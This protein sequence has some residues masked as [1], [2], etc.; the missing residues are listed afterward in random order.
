MAKHLQPWLGSFWALIHNPWCLM[1]PCQPCK[2]CSGLCPTFISPS[3]S[4]SATQ[5]R[6]P[7]G[8]G[9][10]GAVQH[11]GLLRIGDKKGQK[12]I[13]LL[14]H[15]L[16]HSQ[17]LLPPRLP[18]LYVPIQKVRLL[19]LF[20]LLFPCSLGSPSIT[21]W[22]GMHEKLKCVIT[23]SPFELFP[24][25]RVI[26]F[27]TLPGDRGTLCV[28]FI[29]LH[30]TQT[31]LLGEVIKIKMPDLCLKAFPYPLSQRGLCGLK[32]RG[33][34][35]RGGRGKDMNFYTGRGKRISFNWKMW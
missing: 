13:P 25:P 9:D 8:F 30:P 35:V 28:A 29:N 14:L 27:L 31:S 19:L 11:T 17:L 21:E 20:H 15:A 12:S 23:Y 2:G 1:V 10:Y 6:A 7:C 32:E 16:A 18:L 33:R 5:Q 34:S 26:C 3:P 22:V 24:S 4:A